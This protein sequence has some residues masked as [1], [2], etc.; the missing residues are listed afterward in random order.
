MN[1]TNSDRLARALT[2]QTTLYSAAVETIE[3]LEAQIEQLADQAERATVDHIKIRQLESRH[4][5]VLAE[6]ED[7]QERY[8]KQRSCAEADAL[9]Y[10]KVLDETHKILQREQNH[11]VS[12]QSQLRQFREEIEAIIDQATDDSARQVA[13]YHTL[14]S[15][16]S[17]TIET[18]EADLENRTRQA[19]DLEL[20]A[21]EQSTQIEVLKNANAHIPKLKT[22]VRR[23]KTQRGEL[24]S[25]NA[26]LEDLVSTLQNEASSS[27]ATVSGLVREKADLQEQITHLKGNLEK[28]SSAKEQGDA[29]NELKLKELESEKADLQEQITHLKGNLEKQSS[30]KE[31]GDA[32]NEL[33]L[34]ELESEKAYL[35]EQITHLKG[36]LEKQSSAKEQGDAD[37]ELK[38]KE[39]ESE[40]AELLHRQIVL[41]QELSKA[42]IQLA[43]IK[44][45][46]VGEK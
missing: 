15:D 45:L 7:L 11:A 44:E 32:D 10:T 43:V 23:L 33:K 16:L 34:K 13:Y 46:L 29:D 6:F 9:Q 38:L 24:G 37:N 18:L 3:R 35:Q 42:E 41:D 20:A 21:T 25:T 31:Q 39:L 30:A 2:E 28:Q 1:T 22:K 12:L 36:N 26:K 5:Q 8:S 17:L 27:Q 40:K 19:R 14:F 4:T